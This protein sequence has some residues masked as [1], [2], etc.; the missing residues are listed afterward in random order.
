MKFPMYEKESKDK[1]YRDDPY[2]AEVL[3]NLNS[4]HGAYL[5]MNRSIQA[6]GTFVQC[7]VESWL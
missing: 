6:E 1:K 5:R 7:E 3:N 4:I 2:R